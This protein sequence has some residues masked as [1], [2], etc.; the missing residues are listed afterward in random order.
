MACQWPPLSSSPAAFSRNAPGRFLFT[1]AV[2]PQLGP[3]PCSTSR[4]PILPPH[5][6]ARELAETGLSGR[7]CSGPNHGW[8]VRIG[9]VFLQNTVG[10]F[11]AES[12]WAI[13]KKLKEHVISSPNIDPPIPPIHI[14]TNTCRK[15]GIFRFQK[16][17]V[18]TPSPKAFF[19]T[20][21]FPLWT[22]SASVK[23]IS[24]KSNLVLE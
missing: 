1:P 14:L 2:A 4:V 16:H 13:L 19:E 21:V 23:G 11:S 15:P 10:I 18:D 12:I 8:K 24:P 6:A 7:V 5:K 17:S 20:S 9:E 3:D 22:A